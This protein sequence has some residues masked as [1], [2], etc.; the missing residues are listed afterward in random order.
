MIWSDRLLIDACIKKGIV[1]PYDPDCVNPASIDLRLGDTF[2]KPH[3]AW[4]T[5]RARA[6]TPHWGD[7]DSIKKRGALIINPGEFVLCHSLEVEN[8]GT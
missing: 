1:T 6:D 3:P 8:W 7:E 5:G 4:G 2:C